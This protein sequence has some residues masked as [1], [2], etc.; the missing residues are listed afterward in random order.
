MGEGQK[1]TEQTLLC[2]EKMS[3]TLESHIEIQAEKLSPQIATNTKTF[4]KYL[5]RALL[6]TVVRTST[7]LLMEK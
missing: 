1:S 4:S 6:T 5:T 3:Q 2:E 7:I